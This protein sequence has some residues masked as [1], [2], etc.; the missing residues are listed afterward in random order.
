[1]AC[2]W[3]AC[4]HRG[5]LKTFGGATDECRPQHD[6]GKR[7]PDVAGITE[8]ETQKLAFVRIGR[9]KGEHWNSEPHANERAVTFLNEIFVSG[10]DQGALGAFLSVQAQSAMAAPE[11]QL[12]SRELRFHRFHWFAILLCCFP[13]SARPIHEYY[14]AVGPVPAV[15]DL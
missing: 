12:V 15:R 5:Y 14:T 6:A 3:A 1:V 13:P 2:P 9:F 4:K 7:I 11:R 10:M 8:A